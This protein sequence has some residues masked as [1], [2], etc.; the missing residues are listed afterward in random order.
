[1]SLDITMLSVQ[2]VYL[3]AGFIA[4]QTWSHKQGQ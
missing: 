4:E 3:L 1:M 2:Q